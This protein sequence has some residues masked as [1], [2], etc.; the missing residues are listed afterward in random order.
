MSFMKTIALEIPASLLFQT[1]E[2]PEQLRDRAQFLL[3]LKLF[4]LGQ[5]TSG[6]AAQLCQISRFSFLLKAGE[7]GVPIADF[8]DDE[9]AA[10]IKAA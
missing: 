5:I 8:S 6:Q 10:E 4:E 2:S 7:H 1:G 9:I 3:A